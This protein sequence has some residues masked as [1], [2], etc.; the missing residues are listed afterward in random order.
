MF[1]DFH[2]ILKVGRCPNVCVHCTLLQCL[3]MGFLKGA[4]RWHEYKGGF[5]LVHALHA[6]TMVLLTLPHFKPLIPH[7][8]PPTPCVP[9]FI[10]SN[11]G[12]WSCFLTSKKTSSL[13]FLLAREQRLCFL[14]SIQLHILYVSNHF[15]PQIFF[16]PLK[17]PSKQII[18]I[19]QSV[20][21]AGNLLSPCQNITPKN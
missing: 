14:K 15:L 10:F 4:Q 17:Y 16:F 1:L 7:P 13:L 2:Q 21:Y 6:L 3:L 18:P 9:L 19:F 20:Q 12:F 8:P 11:H 5:I